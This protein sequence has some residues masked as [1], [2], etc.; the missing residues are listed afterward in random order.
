MKKKTNRDI[1][2]EVSL[3]L[4]RVD[5]DGRTMLYEHEVYRILG[6]IGVATPFYQ[7]IADTS[8]VTPAFLARFPGDKIVLK[9]VATNLV[10]KKDLNAVKVV[11]KRPSS[12][13]TAFFQMRQELEAMGYPFIGG[14]LVERIKYEKDLGNEVL[15]GFHESDAFGPVISFSKGGADAEFFATHFSPPNLILPPIDRKWAEALLAST[16]IHEKYIADGHYDWVQKIVDAGIRFSELATF[17]SRFIE[18]GARFTITEFEVNP[19][20]FDHRGRFIALDGYG[21]FERCKGTVAT[22]GD[23]KEGR[24]N[25]FFEPKGIVVV[26]VSGTDATKP[27]NIITRNLLSLGR[28]DVYCVNPKGGQ[29]HMGNHSLML[30]SSVADISATAE[31]AVVAVP[32]DATIPVV[33]ACGQKGIKSLILISG[34]FSETGRD[35]RLERQISAIIQQYDMRVIGPNCLGVYYGASGRTRGINTFFVP[36][37]KFQLPKG[38]KQNVALLSQSGALGLTEIH[39]LQHAIS[40]RAIVSYG[41]Q[42]DVDPSD[43][44]EYF[45]HDGQVDVIGCYIEGFKSGAGRR[46]FNVAEKIRKPVVVYKAGRTAAGQKAAQSHTAS[47]AGEYEVA[48]AA[49]KQAGL[50]V[51]DTMIDHGDFIKTFAMFNDFQLHGNR[52]AIVANAGYEKTYAAD[53]LGGLELATLAPKTLQALSNALPAF[54][55]AG[56]LLDLTPMADDE[57]FEQCVDIMLGAEEVDLLFISIVPHAVV[58]HTTDH[59]V[60]RH[61]DNVAARIVKLVHKHRKPVAVSVCVA[62]GIDAMYNKF[63]HILISNG[64]PTFLAADRA[65][66]CLNEFVRYRLTQKSRNFAEWLK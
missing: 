35:D 13:Q 6:L 55:P 36:E 14:L 60:E 28:T 61:R 46:F 62:S 56:T 41:N 18:P 39:N 20:V 25:A 3:L 48:K 47:I 30:Y 11:P 16:K 15:L 22:I 4:E 42:L 34:G 52:L 19:F 21:V 50:I 24:L 32:A 33:K 43:L 59:E 7:F 27:G 1:R 49:F 64:V 10:H 17:F 51:A 23:E 65:M 53:N 45:S 58:L 31:L 66:A 8:S 54:V 37:E 9:A 29:L 5:A 12:I 2:R 40:P 57:M 63:G 38:K 26:G 44:I